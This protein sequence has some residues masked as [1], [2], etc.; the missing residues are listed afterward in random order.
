MSVSRDQSLDTVRGMMIAGVLF[1]HISAVGVGGIEPRMSPLVSAELA[2]RPLLMPVAFALAGFT[3]WHT[4]NRP[5]AQE[6]P[7][8]VRRLLWPWVLWSAIS[9]ILM[10]YVEHKFP[11]L[12]IEVI[13]LPVT[14]P[15][16]AGPVWFLVTLFVLETVARVGRRIPP[17]LWLIGA[18]LGSTAC[19]LLGIDLPDQALYA[20]PYFAGI[21]VAAYRPTPW[22]GRYAA[23]AMLLLVSVS[24]AGA[25]LLGSAFHTSALTALPVALGVMAVVRS[26]VWCDAALGSGVFRLLGRESMVVYLSHWVGVM[27]AVRLLAEAG[28]ST[29]T[30]RIAVATLLTLG[31]A[32]LCVWLVRRVPAARYLFSWPT[33]KATEPVTAQTS[34]R[35]AHT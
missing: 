5:L 28:V 30:P 22:G 6:I 16:E 33:R 32:G 12:S 17:W 18:V 11:A 8:R 10:V 20:T 23:A 13:L 19:G 1:T 7:A 4:L 15:G 3:A 34:V 26:R 31:V 14:S 9:V 24:I 35:G 2:L 21:A 25:V 27:M 29:P